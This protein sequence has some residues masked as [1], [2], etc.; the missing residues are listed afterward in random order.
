VGEILEVIELPSGE[1]SLS[2]VSSIPSAI[3][4]LQSSLASTPSSSSSSSTSSSGSPTPYIILPKV[5][6]G[7][8]ELDSFGLLLEEN[9]PLGFVSNLTGLNN[10]FLFW[11]ASLTPDQAAKLGQEPVVSLAHLYCIVIGILPPSYQ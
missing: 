3:A 5:N 11:Q 8:N 10:R 1:V 4:S 7:E 2:S 6:V 9:A